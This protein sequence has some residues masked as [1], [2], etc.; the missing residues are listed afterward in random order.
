VG[1]PVSGAILEVVAPVGL[2]RERVRLAA[3]VLL[4]LH[5]GRVVP[6]EHHC[7]RD[8]DRRGH[9]QYGRQADERTRAFAEPMPTPRLGSV[10]RRR[11][12]RAM[13]GTGA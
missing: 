4:R 13:L 8:R 2:P 7:H 3:D 6:A 5:L 12:H 9:D 11:S 1:E 10:S